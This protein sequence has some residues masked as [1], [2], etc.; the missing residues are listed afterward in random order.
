L[1]RGGSLVREIPKGRHAWLQVLRGKVKVNDH[2]GAAGDGF[3]VSDESSLAVTADE[4][5]ELMLFDLA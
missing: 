3:A 2:S 4:A 5:S 1:D